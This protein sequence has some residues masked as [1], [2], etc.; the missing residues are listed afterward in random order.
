MDRRGWW[1]AVHGL[2]KI[3]TQLSNSHT[4]TQDAEE[5]SARL[6]RQRSRNCLPEEWVREQIL[7]YTLV[8]CVSTEELAPEEAGWRGLGLEGKPPASSEEP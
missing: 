7:Q 2:I 8:P 6:T 3:W 4:H 1:A 5:R